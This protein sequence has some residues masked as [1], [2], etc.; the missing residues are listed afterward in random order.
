[1]TSPPASDTP[2]QTSAMREFPIVGIGAS[3]GGLE[4]LEAFLEHLAP[5]PG[6]AIVLV[7]HLDPHH[8]SLMSE[9]L[10]KRT[11]LAV[12]EASDGHQVLINTLHVIPPNHDL[13]IAEGCLQLQP[14][15]AARGIRQPIDTFLRSLAR[16]VREDAIAIILSGT[17]SD[18][19]LGIKEVKGLGGMV[20]VQDPSSAKYDGMPRSAVATGMVDLVLPIETMPDKLLD[21]VRGAKHLRDAP[22]R[23]P[24]EPVPG[25][26]VERILELIHERIGFDFTHYKRNT[27]ERR[28]DKRVLLHGLSSARQYLERLHRDSDN[29][30]LQALVKD[31]LIGVTSFFRD[32]DVFDQVQNQVLPALLH[33]KKPGEPLRVWVAGCSTG[34]EAFGLAILIRETLDRLK[35]AHDVQIFATDLDPAAIDTARAATFPYSIAADLSPERIHRWFRAK[36]DHYRVVKAIREMILFAPHDLLRDP[37]FLNL[38]LISCR[39]LLI[40][41]TAEVQKRLLPAFYQALLPGRYLLLGPSETIGQ[42][43]DLFQPLDEK[44]KLFQRNMLEAK[45]PRWLLP[46]S[47]HH[48]TT[49]SPFRTAGPKPQ[50]PASILDRQL[51]RRYCHPAVLIDTSMNVLYYFGDTSAFLADPEGE[52]TANLIR[53]TREELRMRLRTAV[54]RAFKSNKAVTIAGVRLSGQDATYQL[55]VEPI[56]EPPNQGFA[57]VIFEPNAPGAPA[58][59]APAANADDDRLVLHL[60]E[61]LKIA[62]EQLRNTVEELETANEELKS[63][64]EELM[65]MNEELQSSNEELESSK[66]E[67]QALNEELTTVNSELNGKIDELQ[68]ANSDIE[69]L[70]ASSNLATLFIDKTL[71]VR[72]FTPPTREVFHILP[73]DIGRPLAHVAHRL[74]DVDLAAES[75][76]ALDSLEVLDRELAADDDRHY[77]MR[78]SPYRTVEDVIDGVVLTFVDITERQRARE[79]LEERVAAR[80]REVYEREALLTATMEAYPRG[81]IQ[82]L[83]VELHTLY[84]QGQGL[85]SLGLAPEQAIGQPLQKF[86][87]QEVADPLQTQCESALSG[88]PGEIEVVMDGRTYNLAVSPMDPSGKSRAR[89]ILVARDISERKRAED[90]LKHTAWRLAEAQRFAHVGDWE[91]DPNTDTILWSDELYRIMGMEPGSPLPDYQGN[92]ALYPGE[93]AARLDAAVKTALAQHEPFEIELRLVRKDGTEVRT[94]A[95]GEVQCDAQG[96]VTRLYGSALDVTALVA[97]ERGAREAHQHLLDVLESTTDAFFE[98]DAQFNLTYL[99]NKALTAMGLTSREDNLGRNLWELFPEAVD[100]EFYELYRRAL[101]EQVTVTFEAYYPPFDTWFDVCAYPSRDSLAVYFRIVTERKRME[102]AL[103]TSSEQAKAAN[104]AKSR[105]LANM[106]HELRTPLNGIAGL[107]ALL[108]ET[109]PNDE[110][111]EYIEQAMQSSRRLTRLIADILDLSKIESNHLTLVNEAFE[112]E[113]F[114]RSIEQLFTP[115]ATPNQVK[116]SVSLTPGAPS[117]LLGDVTR[118]HQ[119]LGNL[120]GNAIKFTAAGRVSLEALSLGRGR[121]DEWVILF[122]V[123]DTGIGMPQDKLDQ[124]FEPFLQIENAVTKIADGV[125]LGLSIVKRLVQHMGGSICVGSEPGKGTEFVLSLP[126]TEAPAS[127]T[128]P[129][130]AAVPAKHISSLKGLRILAVDDESTNRLVLSRLLAKQ[131]AEVTLAD[132]GRAT[133]A[134]LQDPE[135]DFDLI[136]LD[137]QMPPPDGLATTA[138]IRSGEAGDRHRQTPIVALTAHAMS[139]DQERFL[140]AGMDG[141]VSKPIDIEVLKAAIIKTLASH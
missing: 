99:N 132:S 24:L 74:R 108:S 18:G 106:S 3:A 14:P 1:M 52:P 46:M 139:G 119:I 10:A 51:L 125:G 82:L 21:Y 97:A 77:L 33:A 121:G 131:G 34:E 79:L 94:I 31:M 64:N 43:T 17:G 8:K 66:E 134:A 63:S 120:V 62:S 136:L 7:T 36:D 116:L 29:A 137:I 45:P 104:Q 41:M 113:D 67:L 90:D 140:A 107:L 135:A 22:P 96:N 78:V 35:R 49:S 86:Y 109:D 53:K 118:L 128:K 129:V 89:A 4:A 5:N 115:I 16:E 56:T 87:P 32:P 84:I 70:L 44:W 68:S 93:D 55:H 26:P 76:Q 40:Y 83:D 100:T 91:W 81:W 72:R 58:S 112:L 110:Q 59:P 15:T 117:H 20:M 122:I 28:I 6:L 126:F 73:A 98:V 88:T 37:P 138:A 71:C 9:L 141:Y 102:E 38:D 103:R 27:L 65:S 23:Q 39:N 105:F 50:S 95:R 12:C 114:I 69:N 2:V 25:E 85:A 123:K 127:A 75:R 61:E 80:T 30:E 47:S 42:A 111:S 130:S 60:E 133:L 101:R 48:S 54:H 19:T 11:D 13:I 57:A 92:L 124:L